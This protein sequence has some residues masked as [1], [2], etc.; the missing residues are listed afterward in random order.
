MDNESL[1]EK[2]IDEHQELF[3]RIQSIK[4][5]IISAGEQ[6]ISALESGSKIMICGNG[7]SASD[8]QHMS[9]ELI[10][11]Y[12]KD[13]DALPAVAL[14][15]DT[16]ILTAVGND[17]GYDSIFEKQVKGIGNPGDILLGISTSGNSNNIIKAVKAARKM[18]IYTIGLLGKD[19]GYLGPEMDHSVIIPHRVTSRIQEAHIFVIHYWSGMI[20][21]G[22]FL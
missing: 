2:Y 9:A 3:S 4:E 19:G 22:L 15:V 11:R 1:F 5:G 10:G 12:E 13:R 17:Y 14:T 6:M 8:S 7:G 21:Q 16:S 20:E 18:N